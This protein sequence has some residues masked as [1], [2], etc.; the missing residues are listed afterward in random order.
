MP[1]IEIDFSQPER[2]L[3]AHQSALMTFCNEFR[4]AR[5]DLVEQAEATLDGIA[6]RFE[7]DPRI[8]I[9]AKRALRGEEEPT[10]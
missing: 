6:A 2:V 9:K 1:D 8:F 10:T 5:P 3:V 4:L 7:L